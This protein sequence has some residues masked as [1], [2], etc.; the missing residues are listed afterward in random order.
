MESAKQGKISAQ[1][2]RDVEMY[3]AA[4]ETLGKWDDSK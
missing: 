1:C 2:R 3:K 4:I